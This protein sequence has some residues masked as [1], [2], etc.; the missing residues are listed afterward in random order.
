MKLE[1][2]V[3]SNYIVKPSSPTPDRLRRY[4]LSFLDQ[5]TLT[6]YNPLVLFYPAICDTQ[7]N[8]IHT[9]DKLKHSISN[10]L[11]YF[12]PLAGRIM[13]NQLFVDCNDEGIPFLEARVKC[14]LSDVIK[15]PV[16]CEINKLLPF[17]LH[18]ANEI[19]LGIQ[20]NIFDCGGIGIGVCISHK[21]G[22]ALSFFTF[23]NMWAAIARGERKLVAPEFVSASL[24]PPRDLSGFKPSISQ[25]KEQIVTKRFVFTASKI[26]EIREKYADNSRFGN[27]T[28]P[29]RIE[30]LS[31]FIWSRFVTATEVRSRPDTLCSIVHMINLRTRIDPPQPEYS[32][33]N[34]YSFAM[35]FPS[36]DGTGE[37]CHNLV[38]QM[39]DSIKKINKECVKKIQDGYNHLD[40]I[41]ETAAIYAKAE[42]LT[43]SFTSLCRFPAYEADFGWGKP[44]WV[45]SAARD[46][47][48][49]VTFL[50][51]AACNGIEAWVSLKEEDMAKFDSDEEFLAYVNAPKSL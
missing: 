7:A 30:A 15:N 8:K 28:R 35:T 1:V 2:A 47:N 14:Q 43:I 50:D 21:I 9:S 23:V 34:L 19:P 10:A 12:Y 6:I 31:A 45:G 25:T 22:D 40:S 39:K 5:L 24:F 18:D 48:N 29:T 38:T 42:M 16:P 26:E 32:F 33:G 44:I 46:I 20:F 11:T 41:R 4:Q 3:I 13:E 51:T 36:M 49:V 17:K 27:Q 37:S